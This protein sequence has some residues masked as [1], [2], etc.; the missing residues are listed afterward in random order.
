MAKKQHTKE[1]MYT[2]IREWESSGMSQAEFLQIRNIATSTFGYWRKKYLREEG[3]IKAP[4]FVPVH[5]SGHNHKAL[6][7]NGII[8]LHYPNG[9]QLKCSEHIDLSRLKTLIVL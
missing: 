8:E 5:I 2:L 4:G 3:S 1:Q 7:S 6:Q 9:V